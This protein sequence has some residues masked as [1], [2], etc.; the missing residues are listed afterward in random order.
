MQLNLK[1]PSSWNGIEAISIDRYPFVIGRHRGN[2][3]SLPLAF[4]SRQ[5][6]RFTLEQGQVYIQDLESYNGTYVN[7][8]RISEPTP[9]HP[10]DELS[11]G[12]LC[13][14]VAAQP[15]RAETDPDCCLATVPLRNVTAA[16]GE[17]ASNA[18][19]QTETILKQ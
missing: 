18:D 13:F 14:R 17:R 7:G 8:R 12:P 10:G 15:P 2:D 4:I 9:V 3:G 5:H 11:L 16:A 6:C 1:T 19:D